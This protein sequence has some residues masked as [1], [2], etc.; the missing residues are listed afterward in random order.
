MATYKGTKITGTST[1]A[2]VF[3]KSGVKNAKKNQTYL[4]TQTGHVYVCS[5]AG[6][7]S[8]AKW[9]YKQTDI[10]AK[11]ALGVSNLGAPARSSY[12]M[13]ASWGV[14]NDLKNAKCG[15]RATGIHVDWTIN[16]ARKNDP[17]TVSSNL[18]NAATSSSINLNNLKIGSK[19]Y[20]RASFHPQ[21]L[22]N[23][24]YST[25][26]KV[27]PYNGKGNSAKPATNSRSFAIPRVPTLDPYSFANDT[28]VLSITIKTDA[29]T[30][31]QERYDTAYT[32]QITD[33]REDAPYY[34]HNSSDTSTEFTKTFNASGYQSLG[35]EDYIQVD[36]AA[37]ARG[38][39]GNSANATRRYYIAYPAQTIIE[40]VQVSASD[41]TGKVTV[42]IDTNTKDNEQHPV[43][44]VKLE[45]LANCTYATENAIPGDASWTDT[46]IVDDDQ[47]TALSIGTTSL[48]PDAGKYT[49]VR[50]KSYHINENVL[51]RYSKPMRVKD[52]ETPASTAADDD[53][54]IL[55]TEAGPDG[56]SI[57]VQLGW[58]KDGL[59]DSTGTELTWS[60]QE[61]A[62]KSTEDPSSYNFTWSDGQK[63][64]GMTT[65]HDSA[66]IT[67]K[68]L[69][70]ATQYFIKARR[71]LDGEPT[72]YSDYSNIETCVTSETPPAVV[73]SCPGIIP[74]GSALPVYW[75]F[76]GSSLQ[77]NW[78]IVQNEWYEESGDEVAVIGRTYFEYDS[79]TQTYSEVATIYQLTS[80][81]A[82]DPDKQYFT[83]TGSGTSQSPYVYTLVDEPDVSD[84]GT[85]YELMDPQ[86]EGWYIHAGGAIIASGE[87]SLGSTQ[88]SAERLADFITADND[89]RFTVQV[90]TGSGW[91]VSEQ[92][93]VQFAEAPTLTVTAGA[94]LTAQP[95][96]F[97]V[98]SN[99]ECDLTIVLSAQG[100]VG[101]FPE[102][103]KRQT[104]N[105]T[106]YSGV[107]SPAW[108]EGDSDYTATIT[109][110]S[111]LD[112]WNLCKYTLS[113]VATDNTTGL[114]SDEV[115]KTITIAWANPAVS[116][117]PIT[118]YTETTDVTVNDDKTYFEYDSET[119]TYIPV[120][121]VG[122]ENPSEEGW[123]EATTTSAITLTPIDTVDDTG[124][125]RKAVQIDLTPATGCGQSD[126]YDI[127]RLT[128]DGA[129]LIGSGFP[130]TY[131]A[132]DEYAPFGDDL[133]LY[134]RVAIRTPDG[135]VSFYDFEYIANGA[136]IRFDWTGGSLEL[137]YNLS[138]GDKYAKDVEV[139]KHLNGDS[140]AY[141]NEGVERNGSL[142]S[143]LIRLEQQDDVIR[144]RQLARYAG[145]VFVRTPDGSAY[146]AD[147]EV[148]DMSTT[149]LL[150]SIAVDAR[151]IAL[152]TAFML[153]TPFELED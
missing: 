75:V 107:V 146:E 1:T 26:I 27:T 121:P 149:G 20:T 94:T 97:A 150:E 87:N 109:L 130:L 69:E 64:V 24:L 110:P 96:S 125:H 78:Q 117:V 39:A 148:T 59:D 133:T 112:L 50:V 80:D 19:T 10:I 134:Y 36:T 152:T 66:T 35:F 32:M 118:T 127:Y 147:V 85:Y 91:V 45:Y 103:V 123:F 25:S 95:L 73:A 129:Y 54:T 105:D 40:D 83:R 68:N 22:E 106:I 132:V 11:P 21:V 14:P 3:K 88:I 100:A 23:Y 145:A 46:D 86:T 89:L 114:K 43:D 18:G 55:S 15:K 34:E 5:T 49:W 76:S 77:T 79:V 74:I 138:V 142:S 53:I 84:I 57:I 137:P 101:Q 58:N 124:Y 62:W 119:Q 98:A 135:D 111:G 116:L 136:V 41:T 63:V 82:I 113:V 122:T 56:T 42:Y 131:T 28:G 30:D 139:R 6:K 72:T 47:C 61:D 90:S 37:C 141:W 126:V 4:N 8:A 2:K 12:T 31:Y 44:A 99:I 151:E 128:G 38:F 7:P 67:I 153:P 104:A 92:H 102:G 140:D 115:L 120:E 51:Y 29:G 143:D 93:Y 48:I 52:L 17:K 70:E 71:Y 81:V 60:D 65:Y 33:S 16:Q 13:S 108:T 144:A 9:K